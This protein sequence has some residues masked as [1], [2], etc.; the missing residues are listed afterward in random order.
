MINNNYCVIMA[1]GIGSRF[2]PFSRNNRPKQ[3]LD[4]F[5][6]GRS[7]LQMTVD[8]FRHLIPVEN[9]LVVTNLSYRDTILSQI[10]DLPAENILCEP[11]RRNTAPCIAYAMLHIAAKTDNAN[12]VI[13][14]SDHLITDEQEF[15]RVIAYGL[16]YVAAHDALLTIGMRP[17]RPETGYGYIPVTNNTRKGTK[18]KVLSVKTFTEKP[19]RELAEV[20]VRS[21]E[22]LWNSGM[23][24]WNLNAIIK[25]LHLH[26]PELMT[27]LEQDSTKYTSAAEQDYIQQVFPL[28]PNISIDYGV[29]E[30]ASNVM[31]MPADF[32]WSD[33]GTWG[34]LYEL[35]PKDA[36]GNVA[37]HS[38]AAFY[39]AHGNIVTLESGKLAVIEGLEDYIV[40]ENEGVLLVCRKQ[41]EQQIRQMVNDMKVKYNGKYE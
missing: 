30:K 41:S 3:F 26:L 22:F 36:E 31:V 8:R 33:L 38:N 1:G 19:N 11:C 23:F 24:L 4:F 35:S 25:A 32:G 27:V 40:A 29:M 13:A 15:M 34:S 39:E 20:F 9:M 10:P 28:C 17:T 21:G 14:A 7:L 16:D 2:W 6:T 12:I 5:G 37:I 18:P